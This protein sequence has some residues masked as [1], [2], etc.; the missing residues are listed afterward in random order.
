VWP[1]VNWLL[2]WSLERSG[3]GERAALLKRD[4]L[5]QLSEGSF[6]EYYEPFTGEPLGSDEQSW[7]AAVLLD[8]L[9]SG[10][11]PEAEGTV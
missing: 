11:H 3:E 1:V 2:W 9:A 5:A 4:G 6:G 10:P 7:T 8:W